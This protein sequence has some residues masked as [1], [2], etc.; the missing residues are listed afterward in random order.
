M[1][2]AAALSAITSAPHPRSPSC[3]CA[4]T[5]LLAVSRA[6]TVFLPP[7]TMCAMSMLEIRPPPIAASGE[8]CGACSARVANIGENAPPRSSP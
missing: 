2:P 3:A 8:R 5:R 6:A 1:P 4:A 7:S